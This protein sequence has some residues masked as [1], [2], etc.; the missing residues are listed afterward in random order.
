MGDDTD[1]AAIARYMNANHGV[2]AESSGEVARLPRRRRGAAR[3]SF[4]TLARRFLRFPQASS[5]PGDL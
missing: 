2:P 1:A 5:S 4:A 3:V